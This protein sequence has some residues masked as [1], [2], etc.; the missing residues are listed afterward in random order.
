MNYKKIN[1]KLKNLALIRSGKAIYEK[2]KGDEYGSETVE[3]YDI[4]LEDGLFVRF[5]VTSDSYGE[6]EAVSGVEFVKAQKKEVVI[7]EYTE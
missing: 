1:D 4:G 2:T 3:V 5:T 6:N 7:Y